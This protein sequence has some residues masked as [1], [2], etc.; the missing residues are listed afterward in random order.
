MLAAGYWLLDHGG[1]EFK[2]DGSQSNKNYSGYTE[3]ARVRNVG[4]VFNRE[5][6]CRGWPAMSSVE[7]KPLPL[8]YIQW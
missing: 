8:K 1:T 2:I 4:A 7:S 5:I 3:I 6:N